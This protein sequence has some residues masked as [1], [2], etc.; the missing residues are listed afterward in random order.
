MRLLFCCLLCVLALSVSAEIYKY[1]DAQ[2][3][4]V[5]TNQ[6]PEGQPVERIELPPTNTVQPSL[7]KDASAPPAASS[8]VS[9]Y[10]ILQLAGLPDDEALRANN[11]TFTVSVQ[12]EPPLAP[13]HSLQLL[14]DGSPH[15][16]A[17]TA[18][19]LQVNQAERGTH[20]LAVQVLADGKA[21]QQSDV[22][23]FTVQ[24][25]SINSPA[26]KAVP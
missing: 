13:G 21:L 2:G 10:R 3:K 15:G 12:I 17:S 24:R 6:P 20:S 8:A 19:Q 22:L 23:T 14:L 18:M 1:T 7:P 4:T 26:R 25:I 16:P 11:G 9:R 5:F